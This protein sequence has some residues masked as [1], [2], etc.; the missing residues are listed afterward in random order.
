MPY[1]INSLP[2]EKEWS[3]ELDKILKKA[4]D[5]INKKELDVEHL[6]KEKSKNDSKDKS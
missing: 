2:P 3:G 4:V 6:L 1:I 5:K